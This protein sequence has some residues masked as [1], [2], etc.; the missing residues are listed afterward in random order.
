MRRLR[1]L[2]AQRLQ[3]SDSALHDATERPGDPSTSTRSLSLPTAVAITRLL[4]RTRQRLRVA[5]PNPP[6]GGEDPH[7]RAKSKV[8]SE[9]PSAAK[10]PQA[11]V[12]AQS[13]AASRRDQ[14]TRIFTSSERR[15]SLALHINDQCVC[16]FFFIYFHLNSFTLL[17]S[18]VGTPII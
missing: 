6:E 12:K 16:L 8:S 5:H 3:R 1:H 9:G 4:T 2:A 11:R 7:S 14:S 10:H 17:L 13:G 18:R 15:R